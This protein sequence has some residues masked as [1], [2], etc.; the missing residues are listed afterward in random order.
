LVAR[1]FAVGLWGGMAL[2]LPL[3]IAVVVLRDARSSA[4]TQIADAFRGVAV[5]FFVSY[6]VGF[7]LVLLRPPGG[8]MRSS[9]FN[10][11]SRGGPTKLAR[12][13]WDF[14]VS[15]RCGN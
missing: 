9:V 10:A 3:L 13:L 5:L 15:P 8:E 4:L 6:C 1:I 2:S 11:V 14:D 12:Y 7:M